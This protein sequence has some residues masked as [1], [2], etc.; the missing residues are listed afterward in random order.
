MRMRLRSS[1]RSIELMRFSQ[2]KSNDRFM[3]NRV[4]TRLN[5]TNAEAT[6]E[7]RDQRAKSTF[8][9]PLMN[10]TM[11]CAKNSLWRGTSTAPNAKV[12]VLRVERPRLVRSAKARDK[13]KWS[14]TWASCKCRCN[15]LAINA[16]VRDAPMR[17]T[18][19]LARDAKS[20]WSQKLFRSTS[21]KEWQTAR[22]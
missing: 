3:T 14:R 4:R 9:W 21:R 6:I 13:S 10:C 17:K 2:T 15:S 7:W 1:Q 5:A 11:A 20:K 19:L 18:A 8:K 16:R 12:Q 22:R